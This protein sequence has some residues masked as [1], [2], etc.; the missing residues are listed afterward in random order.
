M[1]ILKNHVESEILK[2]SK[3]SG[4]KENGVKEYEYN[5]EIEYKEKIIL[6]TNKLQGAP[7]RVYS[8][9]NLIR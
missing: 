5:K 1:R 6:E 3:E 7:G 4:Q 9:E 8:N 2:P